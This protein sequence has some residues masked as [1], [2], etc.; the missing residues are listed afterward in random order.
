MKLYHLY[1]C[2]LFIS[3]LL[4]LAACSS[5]KATQASI[6]ILIEAD[7]EVISLRLSAGSTVQQA[8]QQAGI[9]LG[10]LDRVDPPSYTLLSDGAS[11][12]VVRV[13]EE[14]EIEEEVVPFERQVLQSE[15]LPEN[16]R[17]LVQNGVNG[18]REITYRLL[19]EDGIEV[20]RSAVK[21]VMVREAVPEILMVGIRTPFVP[22]AI[23]GR[24]VYLLGG[25]AWLMEA[26]TA[27]RRPLINTGDL[28][29][30]IFSLSADG[31]W[32]LYT[33]RSTKDNEIN[34]LWAADLRQNPAK[35][36]D[37]R[38]SN[39][40]HFADWVPG[41][42]SKVVFSTVEPRSAAPGWQANNDLYALSFSPSGWVSNWRSKPVL[43]ANS[44]GV[45]GWWGTNF[46]WAPDGQ[47]LAFTRPDSI[48][49]LNYKDGTMAPLMEIVPLQTREDWAWVPGIA[50]GPDGNVLYTVSHAPPE[51]SQIFDLIAILVN[52]GVAVELYKEVGM[53]AY[54]VTSPL[55]SQGGEEK[56]FQVAFLQ[57]SFPR[58]S[59]ISPYRLAVMDRDGSNLAVL[60]PPSGEPG[61]E[62]QQVVWSPSA[63][64]EEIGYVI[65]VLYK[66]NLW[67]VSAKDG[68]PRQ[69]T[70]D[71]LL[72][73]IAWK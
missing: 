68:K 8:L 7:G 14:F 62:P 53:F 10:D 27:N 11:V 45:Y 46:A 16:E 43:E 47:T 1:F 32:L 54:P 21:V 34:T 20:S 4:F 50:W 6:G 42:T 17:L 35:E 33:R 9:T 29:G 19:Y 13:R 59:D 49:L 23:P 2:G 67:F 41:S 44:G 40:V 71:G 61:L 52:G 66:G 64:D 58:Q 48:G 25:N 24:L 69:V 15:S 5:P 51:D 57:A 37:L 30:R 73:R 55:Q 38:V 72:R 31:N 22:I 12:R 70:G 3:V 36:I 39:V 65:A 60:F 26:S 56:A 28:D 63:L 18:L